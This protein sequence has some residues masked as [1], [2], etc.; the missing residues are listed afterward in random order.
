MNARVSAAACRRVVA[1]F[2]LVT[3]A[4]ACHGLLDTTDPTLIRNQDIANATGA[5]GRR[6]ALIQIWQ[7]AF[8]STTYYTALFS[9][10]EAF[11]APSVI[12]YVQ[13]LDWTMDTRDTTAMQNNPQTDPVLSPQTK[14][15]WT[16]TLA[17]YGLKAYGAKALKDDYIAQSYALRAHIVVQ[18]AEALCPGFPL[19]DVDTET[20]PLYGKPLTTDSALTYALTQ[21]DSS[22]TYVK[23][24]TQFAN[25]ARVLRGRVLL[26]LGRYADAAAAV[27]SVPD[28]FTYAPEVIVSG[29]PFYNEYNTY[30]DPST[31]VYMVGDREG[32]NGLAYVSEHDTIRIPVKYLGQRRS[33]PADSMFA[34]AKYT[35]PAT[36]IP[37]ATGLEARLIAMEAAYHAN[38]PAWF[39]TLNTLRV[40][41][42][43]AP[44]ATMPATD[45]GRVNL[46]FH[47]RAFWLFRTG[48][49]LG[50]MR[51][52]LWRYHRDPIT[53]FPTGN[54][55][56]FGLHYGPVTAIPYIT[57]YSRNLNPNI[58]G[59][60][61]ADQR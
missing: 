14:A 31:D 35:D 45:T 54:Y 60:C 41:A 39:T 57:K 48:H 50:D 2:A 18:M 9:D 51:R 15:F 46:I 27:A 59:G 56:I 12:N 58:T 6:A 8:L 25:L 28:D 52:L 26:D 36:P 7:R 20:R 40:R 24:S 37:T 55:P 61:S 4:A 17:I 13:N 10:E 42:G 22:L 19:S 3:S 16:S 53:V 44:V 11:D 5:E 30:V 32:T 38:D 29:N 43:L 34:Q 21:L 23:D 1:V 33:V 47:E 49:R